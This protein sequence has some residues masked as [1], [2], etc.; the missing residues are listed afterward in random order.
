[1]KWL[2]YLYIIL[3]LNCIIFVTTTKP[4]IEDTVYSYMS[5]ERYMLKYTTLH[6]KGEKELIVR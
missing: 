5:L 1:M 6:E 2:I 4:F 3:A